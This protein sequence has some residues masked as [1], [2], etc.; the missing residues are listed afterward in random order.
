VT[1]DVHSSIWVVHADGTSLHEI[2]TV[3]ADG[4]GLTQVTHAP[5]SGQ[6]DWGVHPVMP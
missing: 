5:G 1:P 2:Y 4:T 6:P 3:N